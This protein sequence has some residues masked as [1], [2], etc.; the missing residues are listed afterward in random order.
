MM[1][2]LTEALEIAQKYTGGKIRKYAESNDGYAFSIFKV[3]EIVYG[4]RSYIVSKKTGKIE[5]DSRGIFDPWPYGKWHA[6]TK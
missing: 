2:T 6:I 5:L 4:P 1:I 3:G